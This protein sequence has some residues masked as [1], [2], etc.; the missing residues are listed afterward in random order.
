MSTP[1]YD[2][3]PTSN[4]LLRNLVAKHAQAAM[5]YPII[6][7]KRERGAEHPECGSGQQGS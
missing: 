6:A 1:P 3:G 4:D 2:S 7:Q 5:N